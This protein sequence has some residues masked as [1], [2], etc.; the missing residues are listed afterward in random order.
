MVVYRF[1][2]YFVAIALWRAVRRRRLTREAFVRSIPAGLLLTL[3]VT[4]FFTAIKLTSVL[5]ATIIGSLQPLLLTLYGVRF[6]GESVKRRDAILG[7]LALVGVVV[8]VVMGSDSAGADRL[9]DLAAVGALLSWSGYFIMAKR[10]NGVVSPGDLTL[11]TAL[12]VAVLNVPLALLFGHSLAWPAAE[13]WFWI[14]GLALGAGV[15]GHNLMNWSL[16]RIPLWLG[17]TFTLLVPVI[18]S[19]LAWIFLDESLNPPQ[20]VAMAVT[21]AAIAALVWLPSNSAAPSP[22]TGA[23]AG[24]GAGPRPGSAATRLDARTATS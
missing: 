16:L 23:G 9:G 21:V 18:S 4:F 22:D 19:A 12:I 7:L 2:T 6:L 3:D 20:I 5:N 1:G 11:S 17:S 13:H 15:L 8:I 10:A 14:I 24:V